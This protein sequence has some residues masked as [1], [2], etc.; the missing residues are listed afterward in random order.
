MN[1]QTRG[2]DQMTVDVD[3]LYREEIFTDLKVATLRRLTP[4][5]LDGSLDPARKALFIGQTHVM[6]RGGPV[7][8]EFEVDA[9]TMEEAA[10]LFPAA[11]QKAVE[12]MMAEAQQMQRERASGLIVP[13]SGSKI[14]MP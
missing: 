9:Q 13:P 11:V 1:E 10:K 7:P 4:V 12:E 6:T 5:K 8:L 2:L 14:H 3:N